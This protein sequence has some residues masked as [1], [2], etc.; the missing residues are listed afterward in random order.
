MSLGSAQRPPYTPKAMIVGDNSRERVIDRLASVNVPSPEIDSPRSV[1]LSP[2][3]NHSQG[4]C[5]CRFSPMF[6]RA[7]TQAANYIRND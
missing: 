4:S 1:F 6:L 7:G 3:F 2:C 5:S